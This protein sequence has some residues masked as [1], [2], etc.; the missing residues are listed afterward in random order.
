V[1]QELT[2]SHH[3]F[4]SQPCGITSQCCNSHAILTCMGKLRSTIMVVTH[5]CS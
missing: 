2:D 3:V 5:P 1:K 4:C